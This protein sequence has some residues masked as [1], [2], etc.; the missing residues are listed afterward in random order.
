MAIKTLDEL[1]QGDV[2]DV[3]HP[4]V[5]AAIGEVPEH[6]KEVSLLQLYHPNVLNSR[7]D[8]CQR[9]IKESELKDLIIKKLKKEDYSGWKYR[10]VEGIKNIDF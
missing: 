1:A 3:G 7:I 6:E 4:Y 5:V 2:V 8:Y 9:T 10:F